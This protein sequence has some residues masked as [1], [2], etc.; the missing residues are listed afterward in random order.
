MSPPG[1]LPAVYSKFPSPFLQIT[2]SFSS[3]LFIFSKCLVLSFKGVRDNIRWMDWEIVDSG[4][5]SAQENM[6]FDARLLEELAG[7]LRPV[8]HFYDWKQDSI[9]HGIFVDPSEFLDLEGASRLGFDIAKRPTGGGIVFHTWDLAF[10]VLIPASDNRYSS[11]TL[12]NYEWV[13]QRVLQ[14]VKEF[15]GDHLPFT[16]TPEDG[17][18]ADNASSRF[19]M[20]RPTKYDVVWQGRKIAGAAQRKTRDGFL[21]QGTIALAMPKQEVLHQ[22]LKDGTR[23]KEAM[24]AN[25]YPLAA[26]MDLLEAR[27]RIKQL[28]QKY[29]CS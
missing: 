29:I 13:N 8:L 23:V 25:T 10:S 26:A 12:E 9:T 21:H 1:E 15:V 28:L 14:A 16:L 24:L 27:S 18:L 19:C 3:K 2:R 7:R 11:K 22:I 20:A 5:S 6:R 17:A 4:V